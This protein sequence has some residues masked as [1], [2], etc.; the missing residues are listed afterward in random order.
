MASGD[1]NNLGPGERTEGGKPSSWLG[2]TAL[3]NFTGSPRVTELS[4]QSDGPCQDMID[5]SNWRIA[6]RQERRFQLI[7]CCDAP[8]VG[9]FSVSYLA[10][11][12]T[13]AVQ[14]FLRCFWYG[15]KRYVHRRGSKP[16]ERF[17]ICEP[18]HETRGRKQSIHCIE[19]EVNTL[20]TQHRHQGSSTPPTFLKP[21]FWCVL[22][23]TARFSKNQYLISQTNGR[24]EGGLSQTANTHWQWDLL[25]Q[26]NSK[27][28]WSRCSYSC[29]VVTQLS[30]K[31]LS[32]YYPY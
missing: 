32:W 3:I 28:Q 17:Q 19:E 11:G 16:R 13:L 27:Y 14:Y 12:A 20:V 9:D 5:W 6:Q 1:R 29:L 26:A 30:L 2:V 24:L 22:S 25:S 31:A 18:K 4:A 15:G 7:C 8:P 23:I 21:R 10:A